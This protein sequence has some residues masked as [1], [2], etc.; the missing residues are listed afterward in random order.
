MFH[1]T[2]RTKTDTGALV[3]G[4]GLDDGR[5]IFGSDTTVTEAP[6]SWRGNSVQITSEKELDLKDVLMVRQH[7]WIIVLCFLGQRRDASCVECGQ[8]EA[9][10]K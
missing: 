9:V 3:R 6:F 2:K 8:S 5:H 4:F 1:D 10:S 7:V